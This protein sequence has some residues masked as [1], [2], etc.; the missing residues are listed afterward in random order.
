MFD[1][2]FYSKNIGRYL[3]FLKYSANKF[4]F[5]NIKEIDKVFLFFNLHNLTD[6]NYNG[7]LSY[8]FF[9]KYY[10]G[11]I[12]Y[13]NNYKHE[14]KLN[15]HYYNFSIEYIL[16]N[17]QKYFSIYFFLNDIYY[18]INKLYISHNKSINYWE[19]VIKDM[20]FFLEKKNSL[21][22]FNLKY[23][24]YFQVW[25]KNNDKFKLNNSNLFSFFKFIK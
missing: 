6:I 19:Y 10:F 15:V 3:F 14:F 7:V 25:I 18:I 2:F 1:F 17:K 5:T 4:C 24:L 11:I 20:N 9:F 22:F 12:P 8:F 21:G 13:F 16:K 23:P